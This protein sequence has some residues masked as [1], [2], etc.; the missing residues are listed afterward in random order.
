MD[1]SGPVGLARWVRFAVL[2][3]KPSYGGLILRLAGISATKS[4]SDQVFRDLFEGFLEGPTNTNLSKVI[5][6]NW[7]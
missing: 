4:C 3:D 2:L 7:H 6:L 5:V 1:G